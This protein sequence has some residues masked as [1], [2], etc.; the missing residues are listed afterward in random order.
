MVSG[1]YCSEAPF[2]VACKKVLF[3]ILA[4][5]WLFCV[6]IFSLCLHGFP[7]GT[8]VSSGHTSFPQV[9]RF[10]RTTQPVACVGCPLRPQDGLNGESQFHHDTV[11]DKNKGSSC[12][13]QA[14]KTPRPSSGHWINSLAL[15]V[16]FPRVIS[17]ADCI[18][19]YQEKL[20]CLFGHILHQGHY[21]TLYCLQ[22]KLVCL[23]L[24]LCIHVTSLHQSA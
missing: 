24:C 10:S 8:P 22:V 23:H 14:R 2:N 3:W 21:A 6:C 20:F 5:A 19:F 9:H 12:P 1:V 17:S 16:S 4:G 13:C 11:C 7:S 18:I 15:F